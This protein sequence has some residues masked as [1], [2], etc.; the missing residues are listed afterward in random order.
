MIERPDDEFIYITI[1]KRAS[2]LLSSTTIASPEPLF[3][4]LRFN[5][6]L[7]VFYVPQP[8]QAGVDGNPVQPGADI[9]LS[10]EVG[11]SPKSFQ[12]DILDRLLCVFPVS[13][14]PERM[15][16]NP[17]CVCRD[18]FAKFPLRELFQ[19]ILICTDC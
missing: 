10:P 16:V 6:E 4:V 7:T 19:S 13:Q 11:N 8:R 17:I 5:D 12:E 15:I 1:D 2:G 14:H 3:R 18:K 9:R